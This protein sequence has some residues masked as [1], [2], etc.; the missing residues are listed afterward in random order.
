LSK[1]FALTLFFGD[2]R[3]RFGATAAIATFATLYRSC[4]TL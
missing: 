2:S 1:R 3:T 4:Q